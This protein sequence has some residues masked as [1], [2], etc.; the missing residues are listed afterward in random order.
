MLS[1]AKITEKRLH[2]FMAKSVS[3]ILQLK[4]EAAPLRLDLDGYV[5]NLNAYYHKAWAVCGWDMC[6]CEIVGGHTAYQTPPRPYRHYDRVWL[7]PETLE[8]DQNSTW[9][10]GYQLFNLIDINLLRT[11]T[12]ALAYTKGSLPFFWECLECVRKDL[13]RLEEKNP[14]L[15]QSLQLKR[16]N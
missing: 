2:A 14:T 9:A 6:I 10:F 3:S 4:Q 12:Q 13:R 8:R 16:K 15:A 5:L 11:D 1:T 7:N